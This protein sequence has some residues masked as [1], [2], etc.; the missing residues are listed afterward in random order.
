MEVIFWPEMAESAELFFAGYLR[1]PIITTIFFAEIGWIVVEECLFEVWKSKNRKKWFD[2]PP[3]WEILV[4]VWDNF[5][6]GWKHNVIINEKKQI[7]F[8]PCLFSIP[9]LKEDENDISFFEFI[10]N[11]LC[12][13]T[14]FLLLLFII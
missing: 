8:K 7:S 4:P 9:K 12:E 5:F 6:Q 3:S 10:F 2:P 1:L 14:I 11:T 13:S